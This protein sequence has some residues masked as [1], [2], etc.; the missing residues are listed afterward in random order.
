M[1]TFQHVGK[2]V[3]PE[4][5]AFLRKEHQTMYVDGHSLNIL[6]ERSLLAN[7]ARCCRRTFK[8]VSSENL[9]Y[10]ILKVSW[11]WKYMTNVKKMNLYYIEFE[12]TWY[13]LYECDSWNSVYWI[14]K[15]CNLIC[16]VCNDINVSWDYFYCSIQN[17]SSKK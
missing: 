14:C 17:N 10:I 3:S 5:F 11:S 1:F 13:M 4:M 7:R 15:P 12:C 2:L 16:H 6:C 8:L 9:L